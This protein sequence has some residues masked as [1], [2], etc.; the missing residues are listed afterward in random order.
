MD[1]P[2]SVPSAGLVNGKF[3]DENPLTGKPGSLIPA[4]WGNGVT[5]EIV[6]VISAAGLTPNESD[7]T[8]LKAAISTLVEKNR[9]ESFASK[10]EAESG[11]SSNR[12][13]SPLRV[14]QAIEKKLVQATETLFGW[15]RIASQAQ[16][17]AIADDA[18]I[19]TPK[20]LGLGVAYSFG[21]NGYVVLP[22]WLG[23]FTIQW[24]LITVSVDKTYESKPW[25]LAFRNQ[26]R[27]AWASYSHSGNAPFF[28]ITTPPLVTYFDASQ[29]QILSNSGGTGYVSVLSVGN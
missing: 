23:G 3:I 20:K 7:N 24:V 9:N 8:Q 21:E 5:D 13:M 16:V 17:N 10:E 2:K 4:D 12:L 14:F 26:C 28:D 29:V 15:A 6:N 11:T 1:Y 22:S 27:G 25:P 18:T 19:V